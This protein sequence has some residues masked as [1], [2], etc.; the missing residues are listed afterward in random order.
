MEAASPNGADLAQDVLSAAED[1]IVKAVRLE[2]ERHRAAVAADLARHMEQVDRVSQPHRHHHHT[3]HNHTTTTLLVLDAKARLARQEFTP[4]S[5][6]GRATAGQKL[7]AVERV[8][9][10]LTDRAYE[11]QAHHLEPPVLG[12]QRQPQQAQPRRQQQPQQRSLTPQLEPEP[13]PEP[14]PERS[15]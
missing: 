10:L 13:E 1:R 8:E 14:E 2:L 9:R 5:R 11:R 6:R 4:L 12:A 15:A 7:S 3:R